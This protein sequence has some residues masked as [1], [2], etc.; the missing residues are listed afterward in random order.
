MNL[1]S[2]KIK[3]NIFN[4]ESL[5]I[6]KLTVLYY[7]PVLLDIY[8]EIYK[9]IKE[10]NKYDYKAYITFSELKLSSSDLIFLDWFGYIN[11]IIKYSID[12]VIK[13]IKKKEN[14][15][16]NFINKLKLL[17]FYYSIYYKNNKY[18][19]YMS[20]E[21]NNKKLESN[22][23]LQDLYKIYDHQK[24][25]FLLIFNNCY[26]KKNDIHKEI[27]KYISDNNSELNNNNKLNNKNM[28]LLN[29]TLNNNSK[30]NNSKLNNS[31]LNNNKLNNKLNNHSLFNLLL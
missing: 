1:K 20:K 29:L 18:K 30:L 8:Q 14:I 13:L 19:K 9:I 10:H 25:I 28:Y 21:L 4:F 16:I 27:K 3:K 22:L 12:T 7:N 24:Q 6:K 15:S 31:K 11:G 23:I 5:P 17:N 2:N 26:D